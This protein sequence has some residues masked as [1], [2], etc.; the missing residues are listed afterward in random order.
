[1]GTLAKILLQLFPSLCYIKVRFQHLGK[2][3]CG[4]TDF[5]P[6]LVV[7]GISHIHCRYIDEGENLTV[8]II[9]LVKVIFIVFK[10]FGANKGLPL[11]SP[12]PTLGGNFKKTGVRKSL[13]PQ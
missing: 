9:I 1:M 2:E 5:E 11:F 8:T 10:F 6:V 12:F 3:G 13:S 4:I 7:P